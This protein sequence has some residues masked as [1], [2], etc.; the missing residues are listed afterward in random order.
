MLRG[1][2]PAQFLLYDGRMNNYENNPYRRGAS[3]QEGAYRPARPAQ[4]AGPFAN[5]NAQAYARAHYGAHAAPARAVSKKR[6]PWGVVFVLATL[7]L[8]VCL[9]VLGVIAYG[10]WNGTK[11][12]DEIAEEAFTAQE[13]NA[14][15]SMTVDWDALLAQNPD[16]VGWVYMPGTSIDYPIV[17][18]ETDE[19]Y[20]KTD[21]QGNQGLIVSKGAIFLSTANAADF[22]DQNNFVYGHNMNDDTMFAHIL[23]MTD[24]AVFDKSR[25]FF[26]LTPTCNYRCTTL[27]LDVV[28]STETDLIQTSF[29]GESGMRSYIDQRRADS[30][31]EASLEKDQLD[32]VSKLFTLVTCGDDYA[33]TRAVLLGGVVDQAVPANA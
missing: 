28:D 12:Y 6:G 4:P 2:C 15:E 11:V 30:V 20:L 18:G 19:E 3:S 7:V 25:T 17:Q 32:S 10:Y 5:Q 14:L 24:Q 31:V 29:Q 33:A 16:T 9:G 8:V 1:A 13:A 26:I 22:S 21:F 23:Q 27:A